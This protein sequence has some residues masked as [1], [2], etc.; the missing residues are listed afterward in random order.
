MKRTKVQRSKINGKGLFLDEAVKKDELIDYIHGEIHVFRHITPTISK[1]MMDWIGV[2]RFSWIDTSKSKFRFINHSCDPNVAIV[3]KRKV[4]ALKTM[5][6][7]T[8]MVMDYSLTEA[9]NGWG[10][11]CAC[12]SKKCRK[13]I[14]PIQSIPYRTF[15]RYERY[16]PENFRQIYKTDN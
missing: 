16:I 10:I 2:G 6:A 4:V 15:R 13:Y 14:G 12:G 5:P 11:T 8:E 1:R 9:E 7:N 3:T